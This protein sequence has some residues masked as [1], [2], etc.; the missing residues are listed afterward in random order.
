MKHYWFGDSWIVG[1]E[2]EHSVPRSE[3]HLY[4]FPRLVSD[5]FGVE[6]VNCGVSGSSVDS[7]PFYFNQHV[8][9]MSPGDTVFFGLSSYHRTGILDNNQ[10]YQIS[11]GSNHSEYIHPCTDTWFK[12]FDTE[13]HR[14][15]NYDKTI[16]LLYLLTKEYDLNCYFFNLFSTVPGTIIDIVPSKNWLLNRNRCLAD[17]IMHI[18]GN[19][20]GYVI[21]DDMPHL[22]YSDWLK[23]EEFL[24]E[25]VRP[26]VAHPNIRGHRRI[27]EKLIGLIDA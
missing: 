3:R 27:A 8:C 19:S 17:Y 15:Y 13:Q 22:D 6:S 9:S 4:A 11:P 14:L 24:N 25:Y 12:Y 10:W 26:G 21:S 2:L 7:L 5:H 20:A 23:H 18:N 1:D 16:G